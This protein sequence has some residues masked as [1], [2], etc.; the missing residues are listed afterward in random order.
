MNKHVYAVCA[1]KE[2]PYLEQCIQSL[3]NQSVQSPI[4]L[5]T[6]TPS[7]LIEELCKKYG[8]P[9]YMNQG[10]GGIDGDWNDALQTAGA[11]YVTL[12]HQDDIYEKDYGKGIHAAIS[13]RDDHLILFTDYIEIRNGEKQAHGKMLKIKRLLLLPLYFE[14]FQGSRFM[15]RMALRFG[16]AICCPSVTYH[17]T[18]LPMPLFE[19]KFKSNLDW[20]T[21]EKLSRQKGRFTYIHEKLMCHRIHEES[22]TSRMINDNARSAEDEQ[23]FKLFW[24]QGIARALTRF[25][26]TSEKENNV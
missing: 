10:T 13:K 15:K 18:V 8:L 17:K 22:E 12:C 11:Q 1:Y 14:A 2:S 24:P 20:Q 19:K 25:Y 3:K 21:W 6:S 4:I 5:C 23:I 9:L 16:N 7:T 26:A